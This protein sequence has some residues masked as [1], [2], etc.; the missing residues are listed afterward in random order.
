MLQHFVGE[1]AVSNHSNIFE[2]NNK[3]ED[4]SAESSA[5][6]AAN[7]FGAMFG[8]DAPLSNESETLNSDIEETKQSEE[9][10]EQKPTRI[11]MDDEIIP[12]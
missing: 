6:S 4:N 3:I 12:Y 10:T 2:D 8:D 7:A 11:N 5:D 9:V 1:H